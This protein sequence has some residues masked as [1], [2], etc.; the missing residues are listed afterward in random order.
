MELF[1]QSIPTVPNLNTFNKS[2]KEGV[3][4]GMWGERRGF[5][6]GW[7]EVRVGVVEGGRRVC[8]GSHR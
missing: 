3:G 4:V 8:V 1:T 7:G 2:R 5:G 6:E